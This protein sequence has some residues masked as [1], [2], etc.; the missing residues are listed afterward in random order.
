M[1]L[2][3]VDPFMKFSSGGSETQYC[4]TEYDEALPVYNGYGGGT[5]E[6]VQW[7]GSH[8][9]IGKSAV[10]ATVHS[11][12]VGSPTGTMYYRIYNTSGVLQHTFGSKD[13]STLTTRV[14][15]Y[16]FESSAY[17]IQDH[18]IL[19]LE[20]TGGDSSNYVTTTKE[21]GQGFTNEMFVDYP[22]GSFRYQS[23]KGNS[24]CITYED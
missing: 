6:G 20:Y 22:S 24:Y 11:K 18:D 14:Q 10:K 4:Q 9:L 8:T 19:V 15:S 13:V 23:D 3:L 5:R 16:Q 1:S 2:N 17:T 12:K 21:N 7:K